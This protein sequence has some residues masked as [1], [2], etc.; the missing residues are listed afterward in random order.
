MLG[1][2]KNT[3]SNRLCSLRLTRVS[4]AEPNTPAILDLLRSQICEDCHRWSRGHR[5]FLGAKL[6]LAGEDVYLIAWGPYL[7]AIQAYGVERK[8]TRPKFRHNSTLLKVRLLFID[9]AINGIPCVSN[10][11]TFDPPPLNQGDKSSPALSDLRIME[12][13]AHE[14][15]STGIYRYPILTEP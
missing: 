3:A 2:W 4:F 7:K 13:Q 15:P 1:H 11:S 8:S 5:R 12:N 14:T 6:V 10:I 9:F